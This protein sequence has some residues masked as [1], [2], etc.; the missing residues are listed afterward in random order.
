[1]AVKSGSD[2]AMVMREERDC[3]DQW[4]GATRLSSVGLGRPAE[5]AVEILCE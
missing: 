4:P 1:M 3:H 5:A 2:G